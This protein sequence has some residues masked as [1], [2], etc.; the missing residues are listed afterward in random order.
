MLIVEDDALIRSMLTDAAERAGLSVQHASNARQA[1]EL[2]SRLPFDMAVLDYSL[3]DG[4]GIEVA[5][6]LW[7]RHQVPFMFFSAFA[8]E[9]LVQSAVELGA[10]G[11]LLKPIDPVALVPMLR[12]ACA[13]AIERRCSTHA[14]AR[15]RT[16]ATRGAARRERERLAAE[17]HDGLGQDLTAIGLFAGN[18][19][20][21]AQRAQAPTLAADAALLHQ[22]V[23]QAFVTCRAL[24]HRLFSGRSALRDLGRALRA[25][26][27]GQ[28]AMPGLACTY[29]GPS[30]TLRT[31]NG[32]QAHHLYRFA[33]EAISNAVR[34]GGA[35]KII[36]EL[37]I[38]DGRVGLSVRDN[39][40]GCDNA[41]RGANGGIGLRTMHGRARAL[42]GTV[43]M[44]QV[45]P[46]GT[47]VRVDVPMKRRARGRRTEQAK[48]T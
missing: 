10:L 27:E 7:T 16:T 17:L 6:H 34:H 19:E 1:L 9:W 40:C 25:L 44:R 8:D 29:R 41:S 32:T 35:S 23:A 46:R 30:S 43:S 48:S 38:R 37:T 14:V 15:A 11:Y 4:S 13:R 47:E 18:L 5:R 26:A 24:S 3:P 36:V 39:G 33:Q 21:S 45:H 28:A 20:R 2:A 12:A 22:L 31:I 42:R